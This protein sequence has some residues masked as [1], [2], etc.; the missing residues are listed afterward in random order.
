VLIAGHGV[1][2]PWQRSA[3]ELENCSFLRCVALSSS[4]GRQKAQ[5][6]VSGDAWRKKGISNEAV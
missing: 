5:F 3:A 4:L 2:F 1:M 6:L